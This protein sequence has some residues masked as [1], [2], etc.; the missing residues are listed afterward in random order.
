MLAGLSIAALTMLTPL[1]HGE[2]AKAPPRGMWGTEIAANFTRWSPASE[3]M[4]K[5]VWDL[6]KLFGIPFHILFELRAVGG[7]EEM[8]AVARLEGTKRLIYY[9]KGFDTHFNDPRGNW[10]AYIV[11]LHEV[12]HHLLNHTFEPNERQGMELEADRFAGCIVGMLGGTRKDVTDIY[13]KRAPDKPV[14]IHPG[15]AV[16]VAQVVEGWKVGFDRISRDQARCL[17]MP[18]IK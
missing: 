2:D 18:R 15:R 6:E 4:K 13:D 17:K 5:V 3:K 14:G 11:L 12:G 10:D 7:W 1:A 9:G 16:R 8:G